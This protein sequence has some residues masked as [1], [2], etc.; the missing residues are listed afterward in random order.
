MK[1]FNKYLNILNLLYI[2][3]YY[4][5]SDYL[6]Y[7]DTL[8]FVWRILFYII[9]F[10]NVI[11][12]IFNLK[13]K[14]KSIGIIS[15]IIGIDIIGFSIIK[16]TDI[17]HELSEGM[18]LIFTL[19]E[20]IIIVICSIV[21]LVKNRKVEQTSKKIYALVIFVFFIISSIAIGISAK[22]IHSGNIKNFDEALAILQNQENI[23]TYTVEMYDTKE[24]IFVNNDGK[25]LNRKKYDNIFGS[26]FEYKMGEKVIKFAWGEMNKN[27]V[28][29]DATGETVCKIKGLKDELK[30]DEFMRDI[31]KSQNYDLE[32]LP[33]TT[34][35]SIPKYNYLEKY[36]EINK[37]FEDNEMYK[38][39]YFRNDKFTNNVL[40]IVIK[41]EL[42]TDSELI[43]NY[44]KFNNEYNGYDYY[45]DVDKIEEF[46]KYKKEYYL[47]D[48]NNNLKTKLECNNLIYDAEAFD[49]DEETIEK[50]ILF[51]NGNIPFYDKTENGCFDQEGQKISVKP[52]YLLYD[53]TDEY[54]AI[55]D[56]ATK[57]THLLSNETR[58]EIKQLDG[59]LIKYNGFYILRSN[60]DNEIK[61]LDNNLRVLATSDEEPDFIGNTLFE[62]DDKYEYANYLYCYNNGDLKLI[63]SSDEVGY[64]YIIKN[65]WY[66]E[67]V[68]STDVY[69][70]IGIL[71]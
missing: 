70:N 63:Y 25:E 47:I 33:N 29:I 71:E 65:S 26:F 36:N 59:I 53:T 31:I 61:L 34:S 8:I 39:S 24:W 15:I 5:M 16:H 54:I 48:F 22:F 23:D 35:I 69:S 3:I 21:N 51:T 68:Y 42:E 17:R 55:M 30:L 50:I 56:R 49:S 12:G 27:I 28:L 19:L 10:I 2:I 11:V 9:G 60:K 7:Y 38:Y 40:Q 58:E 64:F 52:N 37:K 66:K 6:Y 13:D 67:K 1:S 14:N 32:L 43:N 57:N 62:I 20:D 18:M 4:F 41:D 46:Y 44:T 45:R